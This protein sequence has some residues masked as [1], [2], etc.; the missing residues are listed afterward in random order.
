MK[1][2][3]NKTIYRPGAFSPPKKRGRVH[4]SRAYIPREKNKGKKEFCA[5]YIVW[6]YG[7]EVGGGA[8]RNEV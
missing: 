6:F 2:P 7:A 1:T 8:A 5:E 3:A 4:K